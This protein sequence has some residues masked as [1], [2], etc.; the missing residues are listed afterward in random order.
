MN[1][2][3]PTSCEIA[4]N[5]RVASSKPFAV[6][7][8]VAFLNLLVFHRL[9]IESLLLYEVL[10]RWWH[11]A[12]WIIQTNTDT[13]PRARTCSL[14]VRALVLLHLW[15][16]FIHKTTTAECKSTGGVL[17]NTDMRGRDIRACDVWLLLLQGLILVATEVGTVMLKVCFIMY[18]WWY[19]GYAS[20]WS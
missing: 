2:T 14:S 13:G 9:C 19:F 1:K 4:H 5:T 17:G 10:K 20:Y 12:L 15:A 7:W 16:G 3:T 11:W 6:Q 8:D 18:N